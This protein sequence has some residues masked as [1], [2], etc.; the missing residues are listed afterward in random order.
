[1]AGRVHTPSTS[2]LGYSSLEQTDI[3]FTE[4]NTDSP[5]KSKK[6][7]HNLTLEVLPLY[8]RHDRLCFYDK[9]WREKLNALKPTGLL[10]LLMGIPSHCSFPVST[11]DD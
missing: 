7:K 4:F 6:P 5:P 11:F 9:S 10:T 1:M 8:H 3:Q 2:T